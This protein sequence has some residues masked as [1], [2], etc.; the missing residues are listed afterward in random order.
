MKPKIV[1][2]AMMHIKKTARTFLHGPNIINVTVFFCSISRKN[3]STFLAFKY[4]CEIL[5]VFIVSLFS[6][7]TMISSWSLE[8]CGL[9]LFFRYSVFFSSNEMYAKKYRLNKLHTI[10]FGNVFYIRFSGFASLN[11]NCCLRFKNWSKNLLFQ[12]KF[13]IE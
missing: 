7:M 8:C 13:E 4:T 2:H 9:K 1:Y 5:F 3:S 6:L 10:F 12:T 11:T